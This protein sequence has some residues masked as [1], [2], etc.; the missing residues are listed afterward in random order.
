MQGRLGAFTTEYQVQ[1]SI[2]VD[3]GQ[4]N[5]IGATG[6]IVDHVTRPGVLG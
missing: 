1:L 3:V 6:R 5:A 2:A 4:A